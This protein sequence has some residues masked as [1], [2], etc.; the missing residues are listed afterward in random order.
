MEHKK[1]QTLITIP[2]ADFI[3]SLLQEFKSGDFT[4][5]LEKVRITKDIA[6][7]LE[8]CLK[9]TLTHK[10]EFNDWDGNPL[11]HPTLWRYDEWF[12]AYERD[13]RQK[14]YSEQE[15]I[16][17]WIEQKNVDNLTRVLMRKQSL[18]ESFA[19][20]LAYRLVKSGNMEIMS[21]MG[22]NKLVEREEEL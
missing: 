4:S 9:G 13:K 6:L 10:V 12:H 21:F 2:L 20:P 1:E 18:S 22:L 8:N 11:E 15:R 16:K 17:R 3:Q 5:G 7:I 14:D 19:R